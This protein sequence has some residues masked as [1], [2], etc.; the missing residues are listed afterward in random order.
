MADRPGRGSLLGTPDGAPND[1]H[2][3]LAVSHVRLARRP[4]EAAGPGEEFAAIGM[5]REPVEHLDP[6]P[7]GDV[8]AV[9]AERPSA[10]LERPPASPRGMEARE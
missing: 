5:R 9:D 3:R 10:V 7:H 8:F 6:R 2:D 4:P 1:G